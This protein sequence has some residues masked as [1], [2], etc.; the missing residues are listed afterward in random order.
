MTSK[1]INN[2]EGVRGSTRSGIFAVGRGGTI[3]HYSIADSDGDG[4]P[5][6]QD[7]DDTDPTIYPGAPELCDGLDN[8]CDGV[9]PANEVDGDGDGYMI[10]DGDCDDTDPTT[11]P[12]APELRE[13][14]TIGWIFNS[15]RLFDLFL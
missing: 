2:L 15:L 9:V 10:C 12:G 11:Y 14:K 3:S 6:D 7:C 4:V 1:T 5:E 13:I 8:D